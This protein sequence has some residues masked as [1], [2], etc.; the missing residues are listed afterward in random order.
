MT[1]TTDTRV[2][3]PICRGAG[4]LSNGHPDPQLVEDGDCHACIGE[5]KVSREDHAELVAEH[6]TDAA[7]QAAERRLLVADVEAQRDADELAR[8][9][10]AEWWRE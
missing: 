8:E 6:M 2:E 1:T 9:R 5:G 4:M 10:D 3:C 7:A